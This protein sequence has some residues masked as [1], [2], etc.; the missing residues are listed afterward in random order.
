MSATDLDSG[1]DIVDAIAKFRVAFLR[2]NM[3]PPTVI[4][5]PDHEEGIR[6]LIYLRDNS[7][8]SVSIGSPLLGKPIEQADG[9]VYMEIEIMGM[10]VRWPANRY[11]MPD[12]SWNH[13]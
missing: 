4:I 9:S 8:W 10:K 2:E 12:G 13:G 3:K 6:F 1:A 7:V 5:L 11:A